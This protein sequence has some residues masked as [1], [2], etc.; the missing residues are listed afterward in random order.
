MGLLHDRVGAIHDA[1]KSLAAFVA[2][3]TQTWIHYL[4]GQA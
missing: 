4:T 1:R 3:G 2:A